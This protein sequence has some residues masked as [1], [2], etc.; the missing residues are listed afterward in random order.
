M[1]NINEKIHS[2]LH[3]TFHSMTS[4]KYQKVKFV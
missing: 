2:I 4:H 3:N 1:Y